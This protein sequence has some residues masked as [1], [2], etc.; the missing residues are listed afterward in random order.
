M[1]TVIEFSAAHKHRARREASRLDRARRDWSVLS[2]YDRDAACRAMTEFYRL[3]F[4][5]ADRQRYF[6][7]T[8]TGNSE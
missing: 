4:A 1:G 3:W 2:A 8:R 7:A 5:A 6:E